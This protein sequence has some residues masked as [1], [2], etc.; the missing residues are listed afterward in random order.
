MFCQVE[1]IIDERE[2]S[3]Q[4]VAGIVVEPIQGEGGDNWASPEFFRQLQRI[5]S[6][7]GGC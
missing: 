7:V 2:A 4:S 1:R 3:G 5:C 6:K